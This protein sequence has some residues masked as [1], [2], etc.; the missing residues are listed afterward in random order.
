MKQLELLSFGWVSRNEQGPRKHKTDP[1]NGTVGVEY[2]Y[3][4]KKKKGLKVSR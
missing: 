3:P 1:E 2:G 4:K